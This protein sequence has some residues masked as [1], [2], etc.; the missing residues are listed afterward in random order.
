VDVRVDQPWNRTE[1][2][3]IDST[4]N[5]AVTQAR[6]HLIGRAKV[7]DAVII[8]KDRGVPDHTVVRVDSE[9]ELQVF[10]EGG[11]RRGLHHSFCGGH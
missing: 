7:D 4:I 5:G 2:P 11:V 6:N 10:D 8:D 9:C 3:A 1:T